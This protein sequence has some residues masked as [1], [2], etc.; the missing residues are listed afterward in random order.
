MFD[1]TI[2]DAILAGRRPG[3][4]PIARIKLTVLAPGRPFIISHWNL[5]G[6]AERAVIGWTEDDK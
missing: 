5:K 1:R 2:M 3:A 4:A 6:I